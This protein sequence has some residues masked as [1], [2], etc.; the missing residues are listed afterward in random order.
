MYA[1]GMSAVPVVSVSEARSHLADYIERAIAEHEPIYLARRGRRV[2]ALISA[3][4]LARLIEL[5]EDM[6]D[7]RGAEKAREEMRATA[8]EPIP[9]E[10]VKAD[11]GL[12]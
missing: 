8:A 9:W 6:Q 1:N 5:A 12:A 7:I 10:D 3:D 4:D 11:L 2:A